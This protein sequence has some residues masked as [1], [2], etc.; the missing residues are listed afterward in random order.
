MICL[1]YPALPGSG[2]PWLVH[3]G[4]AGLESLYEPDMV[5]DELAEELQYKVGEP[6]VE[7]GELCVSNGP[8][9]L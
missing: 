1:S 6:S 3:N 7:S 8:W 9:W 4:L 5:D 2:R